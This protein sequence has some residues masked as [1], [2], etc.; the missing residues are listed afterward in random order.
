MQKKNYRV[1]RVRS[2]FQGEMGSVVPDVTLS[3][4]N[5]ANPCLSELNE[6]TSVWLQ[7]QNRIR[8][9]WQ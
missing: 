8:G 4:S 5:A 7:D 6:L 9:C 3:S 1:N 2:Q